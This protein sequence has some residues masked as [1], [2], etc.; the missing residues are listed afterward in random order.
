MFFTDLCAGAGLCFLS[1]SMELLAIALQVGLCREVLSLRNISACGCIPRRSAHRLLGLGLLYGPYGAWTGWS[2]AG[3]THGSF[4][5]TINC[6]F[7]HAA[8]TYS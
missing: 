4:A 7:L 6:I 3:C 1:G 5:A 8:C 2:R